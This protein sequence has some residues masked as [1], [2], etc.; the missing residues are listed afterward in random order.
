MAV[1]VG[2][3][4]EVARISAAL[5]EPE[6]GG[7]LLTGEAGVGKSSLA[8]FIA[9]MREADGDEVR[10]VNPNVAAS[11][12]PLAGLAA[13]FTSSD[14]YEG[15]VP[16]V[17]SLKRRLAEAGRAV[18]IVVDDV[19]SL[20]EA[21]AAVLVNLAENGLA[22]L[23]MTARRGL[24]LPSSIDHALSS[25]AVGSFACGPLDESAAAEL[26]VAVAEVPLS[27]ATR[28]R[29]YETTRG[30]PLYVRELILAAA[31]SSDLEVVDGIGVLRAVP[32]AAPRLRDLLER[33]LA[34]VG[35]DERDALR[36]IAAA[37]AVSPHLVSP[38]IDADVVDRLEAR[39]MIETTLDGRRLMLRPA[40]PLHGEILRK[41]ET[42]LSLRRMR[43]E[44]AERIT[45]T[46]MRR[47]DDRFRLAAWS[48]DG[49]CD[50]EP[51]V[52]AEATAMAKAA[53]D[54]E[55]GARL[56]R[57]AFDA[58]PT[59]ANARAL[60]HVL[61]NIGEMPPLVAALEAWESVVS[62]DLERAEFDELFATTWFWR[63]ADDGPLDR[64]V[65]EWDALSPGPVRDQLQAAGAGLQITQG[66]IDEAVARAEAL[67]DLGPGVPAVRVALT[68]GHGWRSQ[69]RPLAAADHVAKTLATYREFGP[70][71]FALS[72]A[73]MAG[74]HVQA[75]ADAGEFVEVDRLI[76]DGADRWRDAGDSSN[77][78]LTQLA[79][80]WSWLL[81]G[82]TERAAQLAA[83]AAVG[84]EVD[85]QDGMGRWGLILFALAQAQSSDPAAAIETLA[86]LDGR[87]KHP[88]RIFESYLFRA[89]GW[90]AYQL[91]HPG[92]AVEHFVSGHR[93]AVAD[94]NLIAALGC[95]HDLVRIGRP[96]E[97]AELLTGL[98]LDHVEGRLPLAQIAHVQAA[99]RR[100]YAPLAQVAEEFE[101]IGAVQ[102]AANCWVDAAGTADATSR[103][104][105]RAMQR[106]SDLGGGGGGGVAALAS[107]V[108]L[109]RRERDVVGLV[110][111]G[112]TS[113][114][115]AERLEISRRT[116]ET[117]LGNAYLKV[118][119][120]DRPS[121]I[122]R[123]A[124]TA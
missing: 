6:C 73:V 93:V 69:G 113:R 46:G 103:E 10:R 96:D 80:G 30:N 78:A 77:V 7:V 76:A 58:A 15:M 8:A 24:P 100:S 48:L 107:E 67:G 47:A 97:A 18:L 123:V 13:G 114:E 81:R 65:G 66:R 90:V 87:R 42:A 89:R 25:G 121:L 85:R 105:S 102:L 118:G 60:T 115:I 120:N 35:D 75:L 111:L 106:A 5:A 64:M 122:E 2:R 31:E 40:H 88:A 61:Y 17:A 124:S 98:E 70:D 104:A 38:W 119:V 14:A 59:A 63:G 108:A 3:T 55:L 37:G 62:T 57:A 84:F 110:V 12:L 117:H 34:T 49:I 21:S 36:R 109:T 71:V 74:V 28:R 26:A 29:V 19:D 116:V 68:L 92:E 86:D 4:A 72:E 20:D 9:S 56:A 112:L 1:V 94:G 83:E 11:E 54:R 33:R 32:G 51:E 27:L 44:I 95:D 50:V 22:R 52:L 41:G 39:G 45:S 16:A 79:H 53:D 43:G 101:R 82:N 23:L 99:V 91:G